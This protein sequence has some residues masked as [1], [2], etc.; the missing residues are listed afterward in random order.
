MARIVVLLIALIFIVG[1][2]VLTVDVL[3]T[4][5]LNVPVVLALIVLALFAFGIVGA[6][7]HRPPDE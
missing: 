3:I 7:T 5:G 6:L 1:F 2:G 4:G